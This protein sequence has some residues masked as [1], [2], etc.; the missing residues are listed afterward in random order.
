VFGHTDPVE[1]GLVASLNPPGGNL[2][3]VTNLNVEVGPKRV[4]L[5]RELQPSATLIAVLVNL[6]INPLLRIVWRAKSCSAK[7]QKY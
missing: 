4:E 7:D 6:S 3:G 5:L 2:T 1:L